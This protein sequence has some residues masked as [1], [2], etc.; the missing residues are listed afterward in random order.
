MTSY[1]ALLAGVLCGA[2]TNLKC[3]STAE[4]QE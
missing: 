3:A 4:G 2:S 1:K